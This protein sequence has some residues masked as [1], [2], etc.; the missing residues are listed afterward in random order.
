M[1]IGIIQKSFP[2]LTEKDLKIIQSKIGDK[3]NEFYFVEFLK[4][5]SGNIT[6]AY[7]FLKFDEELRC[8]L[9][10]YIIRLEI[11]IK[12]DFMSCLE[13]MTGDSCFWNKKENYIFNSDKEYDELMKKIQESLDN[14]NVNRSY[15]DCYVVAYVISFGTFITIFKKIRPDLKKNFIKKYTKKLALK[16]NYNLLHK[17][18]LSI[19][20]LRNRCAHGTHIVS[21]SFVNQLNQYSSIKKIENI[22]ANQSDFS[23]FELTIIY[24]IE[25]LYCKEEL[26]K[27][28]IKL[29]VKYKPLYSKYGG[30]QS[31]NPTIVDKIN[32]YFKII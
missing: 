3:S 31:I 16:N 32:R 20:A 24:M 29:L 26:R 11:Q 1:D 27:G 19:R 6:D 10:K 2:D 21:N 22:Y 9:F 28:L 14:L 25:V 30:K 15:K 17:Y 12:S 4:A 8:Y 5:T 13:K 18:L 7:Q 23:I